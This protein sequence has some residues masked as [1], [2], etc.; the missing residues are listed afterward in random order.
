M[1]SRLETRPSSL[2][3]LSLNYRRFSHRHWHNY[4][5]TRKTEKA[6]PIFKRSLWKKNV[7]TR[8][9]PNFPTKSHKLIALSPTLIKLLPISPVAINSTLFL[10]LS[11]K[12][13]AFPASI[14]ADRER[15]IAG[16]RVNKLHSIS[17]GIY[18][19]AA[20]FLVWLA[21]IGDRVQPIYERKRF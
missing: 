5:V 15:S 3:N 8:C 16:H 21:G 2:Q 20:A 13:L 11:E 18:R 19:S 12:L 17:T 9:S 14:V 1:I 7:K 4:T 10:R 6:H